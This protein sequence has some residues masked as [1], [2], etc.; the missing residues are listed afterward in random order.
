MGSASAF[1]SSGLSASSTL[2]TPPIFAA[3]S[4]TARHPLPAT[5]TCTSPPSLAAAVTA[6]PVESASALLSCSAMTRLAIQSTPA[7]LRSLSTS[8]ST[9]PTLMPASR[10]GGSVTLSLVRRGVRSTPNSDAAFLSSGFFFAFM[11]FGSEA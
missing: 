3:S 6:L 10:F 11:M 4:A 2:E 9:L 5:R 7:S 1:S 8:S